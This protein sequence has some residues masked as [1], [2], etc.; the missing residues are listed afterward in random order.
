MSPLPSRADG[1]GGSGG[2]HRAPHG[3]SGDATCPRAKDIGILG[4]E[5][6]SSSRYVKLEDFGT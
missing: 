2:G 3:V 1:L 6:Y 5:F 4:I